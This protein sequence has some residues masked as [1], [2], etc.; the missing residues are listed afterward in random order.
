VSPDEP[1]VQKETKN[2][3]A[4][5]TASSDEPP[6][7]SVPSSEPPIANFPT[8]YPQ[9][10]LFDVS[11][12]AL[13]S[14]LSTLTPVVSPPQFS[15]SHIG[16]VPTTVSDTDLESDIIANQYLIYYCKTLSYILPIIY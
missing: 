8:I 6:R 15:S 13:P 2:A 11:D 1:E 5:R 7:K 3:I 9:E 16:S 10:M 4:V 14:P 12:F